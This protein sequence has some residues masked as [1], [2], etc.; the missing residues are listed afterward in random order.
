MGV[1]RVE[2]DAK[3]YQGVSGKKAHCE[4]C[5]EKMAECNGHFGHIRLALPAFHIGYL[6]MVMNILQNI[7][8]V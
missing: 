3:N 8:K 4:T 2:A 5:F 7:C 1:V 6:K